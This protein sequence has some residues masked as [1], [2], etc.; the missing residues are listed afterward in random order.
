MSVALFHFSI[1]ME[2][3]ITQSINNYGWL[4]VDIFFVISG[5]VIPLYLS[6]ALYKHVDFFRFMVKRIV[7]LEPAYVISIILTIVI[8]HLSAL[9][10]M[11]RGGE[12][13]Y[14]A[15][16]IA[17]HLFYL[18]P[19]SDYS[20]LNPVYWTLAY[21]FVFYILMGLCFPIFRRYGPLSLL[22]ASGGVA[23]ITYFAHCSVDHRIFEFAL[24]TLTFFW[25]ERN[26]LRTITCIAAA[27]IVGAL[28]WFS[29]TTT[30]LV[31]VSTATLIVGAGKI[32]VGK[33]A[34]FLGTISYSLYLTHVQIGGRVV[35][36]G[37]RF[38]EGPLAEVVLCAIALIVSI[39]FAYIFWRLIEAPSLAASRHILL[40]REK[41]FDNAEVTD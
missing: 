15:A 10:P 18:I 24:G 28:W 8:W 20:W 29:D 12:P 33:L 9:S 35:S 37:S 7:R 6:N 39:L 41:T 19:L 38:I 13:E 2:G 22:A 17:F 30:T 26:F 5:F 14:T 23:I 36:L 21:E 31:C 11:F 25:W 40:K 1:G 16:Q 34:L 27:T 32:R 3:A 4:G